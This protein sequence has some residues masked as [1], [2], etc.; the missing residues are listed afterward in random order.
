MSGPSSYR[1]RRHPRTAPQ[2][3][4]SPCDAR[5]AG[6]MPCPTWLDVVEAR[7]PAAKE[8][9]EKLDEGVDVTGVMPEA[10]KGR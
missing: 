6:C 10:M 2:D 7:L 9:L 1:I 3:H 5:A 4:E 8:M